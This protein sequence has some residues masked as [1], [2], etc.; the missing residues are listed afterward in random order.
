MPLISSFCFWGNSFLL[1]RWFYDDGTRKDIVRKNEK[2]EVEFKRII[3]RDTS[4]WM[5][6]RCSFWVPLQPFLSSVLFKT[7]LAVHFRLP[8]KQM[9]LL[10]K[11][12]SVPTQQN[13]TKK[14]RFW[15]ER[16]YVMYTKTELEP[17]LYRK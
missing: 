1:S 4:T 12:D 15:S 11:W 8:W 13:K 3:K 7:F 5:E 2:K 16:V 10:V 17:T 14:K 6:I 9:S